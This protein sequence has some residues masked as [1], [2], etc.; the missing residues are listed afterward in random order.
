[1]AKPVL[2]APLISEQLESLSQLIFGR[3]RVASIKANI[4]IDCQIPAVNFKDTIA[5]KE[6]TISGL[7]QTCQDK[8]VEE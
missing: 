5:S 7:C 4:C 8:L 2:R 1:M 3:S 6:F